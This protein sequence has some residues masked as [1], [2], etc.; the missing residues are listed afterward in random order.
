MATARRAEDIVAEKML[1]VKLQ[2]AE[3]LLKAQQ[4]TRAHCE[5]VDEEG[6]EMD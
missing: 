5:D 6:T 1:L 4:S 2:E 3:A